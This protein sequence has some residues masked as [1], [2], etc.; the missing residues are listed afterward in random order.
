MDLPNDDA[1]RWIVQSY[2]SLRAAH[3]EAIDAPELLLPTGEFFP[4]H[5]ERD[6]K[7][8]VALLKRMIGYAPIAD[9]VPLEIRFVEPDGAGGGGGCGTGACGTGGRGAAPRDAITEADDRYVLDVDV[10]DVSDPAV[11][12]TSLARAIGALVLHEADDVPEDIGAM[13]EIVAAACGYGVLLHNGSYVYGKSCGGARVH[14]ATHL[15]V[16]EH[17]VVLALFCRLHGVKP[18]V[19][20]GHLGTTQREA[21]DEAVAWCDSNEAIV[22]ALRDRPAVL[23]EGLFTIEP[24]RG[25]FGRLFKRRAEPSPADFAARKS[26][27]SADEIRRFAETRALV[28]EALKEG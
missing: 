20:R 27:R 4:D 23:E 2:A 18:G 10:S 21:F 16:A 19:A 13:S 9:D 17:A 7:S 24:V 5:F 22:D 14:Q 3:G 8:V 12:T 25:V 1:L 6:A 11:L 26:T 15:S 28:E